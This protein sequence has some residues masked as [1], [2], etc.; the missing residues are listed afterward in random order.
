M[1]FSRE[2]PSD[3]HPLRTYLY[4]SFGW[5]YRGKSVPPPGLH[6]LSATRMISSPTQLWRCDG[7]LS[8]LGFRDLQFDVHEI[9]ARPAEI[10]GTQSLAE[11]ESETSGFEGLLIALRLKT[12]F[13]SRTIVQ[14]DRG[15]LNPKTVDDMKRVGLGEPHFEDRFEVYSDDQVESRALLT[16]DFMER[17]LEMDHHPRY[18]N[19]QLGFIAGR[20]YVAVPSRDILRFGCDTKSISPEQAAAKVIGEMET[21]F[22]VLGDIDVLQASAGHK[23]PDAINV[24]R[25]AWYAERVAGVEARVEKAMEAGILSGAPIP[26]WMTEDAYDLIDPRLHGLLSPRF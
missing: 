10:T 17:L 19:I 9:F 20:M 24:E 14:H 23:C 21:L 11:I 3:L 4:D 15:P 13:L 22:E 8:G 25:Q 12:S 2:N 16:L 1:K 5:R 6:L 7:H 26:D 18:R